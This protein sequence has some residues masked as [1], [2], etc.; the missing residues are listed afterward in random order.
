MEGLVFES[1][2]HQIWHLFEVDHLALG[3]CPRHSVEILIHWPK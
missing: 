3:R 1:S 2:A